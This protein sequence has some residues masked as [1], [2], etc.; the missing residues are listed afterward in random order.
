[1][2]ECHPDALKVKAAVE[3]LARFHDAPIDGPLQL[4]PDFAADPED[5]A[6]AMR[7]AFRAIDAVIPIMAR[8]PVNWSRPYWQSRPTVSGVTQPNG[9]ILV[10]REEAQFA[11]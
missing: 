6:K 2:G 5:E 3:A 11:T 10:V 7:H 4:G 9:K 8:M 1:M